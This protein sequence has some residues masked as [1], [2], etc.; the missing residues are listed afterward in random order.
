M[1]EKK[2]VFRTAVI[3]F[4]TAL[5]LT[6]LSR[7][8]SF[9]YSYFAT[10]VV[11]SDS[12]ILPYLPIIRKIISCAAYGAAAGAAVGSAA[13]G[14]GR[15]LTVCAYALV[16]AADS[17][18]ALVYDGVSGVLRGRVA[19]AVIYTVVK[20]VLPVMCVVLGLLITRR[21]VRQEHITRATIIAALVYPALSFAEFVRDVVVYLIN[22]EFLPYASEIV[23]ITLDFTGIALSAILSVVFANILCRGVLRASHRIAASG[24][25]NVQSDV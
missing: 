6:A 20:A 17:A 22:V 21:S 2:I 1:T 10:D 24:T 25:D 18:T 8:C 13:F 14:R 19:L 7:A 23:S 3:V 9:M 16:L 11:Y 12:A 15:A 5:V 4:A